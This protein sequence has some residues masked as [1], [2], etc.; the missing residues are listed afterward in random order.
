[1]GIQIMDTGAGG[2]PVVPS[3]GIFG[4]RLGG[5][6]FNFYFLFEINFISIFGNFNIYLLKKKQSYGAIAWR[7]Y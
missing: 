7:F 5:Y 6:N 1:M 4:Q 3:V 2:M